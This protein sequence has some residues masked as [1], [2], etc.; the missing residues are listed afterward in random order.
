M[1]HGEQHDFLSSTS[2]PKVETHY[3][4]NGKRTVGV[5][6]LDLLRK[7]QTAKDKAY[8]KVFDPSRANNQSRVVS[9]DTCF[10]MVWRDII[11]PRRDCDNG[12]QPSVRNGMSRRTGNIMFQVAALIGIAKQ[13]G[14][15]PILNDRLSKMDWFNFI[16]LSYNFNLENVR[17]H[18]VGIPGVYADET[19]HLNPAYNWSI[20][21]YFQSWRYFENVAN[22][23]RRIF[24]MKSVYATQA[25]AFLRSIS[26][27]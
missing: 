3:H 10:D 23:I 8:T 6:V 18:H 1:D 26:K 14:F 21:G 25:R 19:E 16:D 11:R 2:I 13:N 4:T 9:K 12:F 15:I 7:R 22:D 17:A 24:K 27:T 20:K 5:Y